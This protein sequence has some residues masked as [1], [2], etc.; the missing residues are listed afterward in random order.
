MSDAGESDRDSFNFGC[1]PSEKFDDLFN[2]LALFGSPDSPIEL[3]SPSTPAALLVTDDDKPPEQA[4]TAGAVI[5]SEGEDFGPSPA[6]DP[7]GLA[8]LL[9]VAIDGDFLEY[10]R[11][12]CGDTPAASSGA[13]DSEDEP[14]EQAPTEGA[15]TISDDLVLRAATDPSVLCCEQLLHESE[16]LRMQQL[17]HESEMQLQ[18]MEIAKMDADIESKEVYTLCDKWL[19][20]PAKQQD[21]L[22][23]F[24]TPPRMASAVMSPGIVVDSDSDASQPHGDGGDVAVSADLDLDLESRFNAACR[25]LDGLE[26]ASA[27]LAKTIDKTKEEFAADSEGLA[28]LDEDAGAA[29]TRRFKRGRQLD[30]GEEDD[31]YVLLGT[32]FPSIQLWKR[33]RIRC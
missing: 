25:D 9:Q 24:T 30:F 19:T 10:P 33:G 2:G 6:T 12:L 32:P 22:N 28:E 1:N 17:L 14:L 20:S 5:T 21:I 29:P 16:S 8:R 23:K 15:V 26:K 7:S 27:E 31:D 3:G 11:G 13:E 4:P 18:Y